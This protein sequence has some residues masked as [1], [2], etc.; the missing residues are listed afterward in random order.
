[1]KGHKSSLRHVVGPVAAA[2]DASIFGDQGHSLRLAATSPTEEA[3]VTSHA[4]LL[5]L[6]ASPPP[7]RKDHTGSRND[8]M[9]GAR[10]SDGA[11]PDDINL[12]DTARRKPLP[13]DC[14]LP[15][16]PGHGNVV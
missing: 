10:T 7:K 1:M 4:S 16:A 11:R 12:P 3:S 9:G 2:L 6:P 15:R 8:M 13:K 14:N 5:S